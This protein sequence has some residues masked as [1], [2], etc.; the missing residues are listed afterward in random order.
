MQL[1]RTDATKTRNMLPWVFFA[2]L[3]AFI[4][5]VGACRP[6]FG[7]ERELTQLQTVSVVILFLDENGDTQFAGEV[8]DSNAQYDTVGDIGEIAGLSDFDKV[9]PPD[10]IPGAVAAYKVPRGETLTVSARSAANSVFWEWAEDLDGNAV[11]KILTIDDDITVGAVFRPDSDILG[12]LEVELRADIARLNTWAN[13]SDTIDSIGSHPFSLVVRRTGGGTQYKGQFR[14]PDVATAEELPGFEFQNWVITSPQRPEPEETD[15]NPLEIVL[16]RDTT[17]EAQYQVLTHTFSTEVLPRSG[18]GTLDVTETYAAPDFG[19]SSIPEFVPWDAGNNEYLRSTEFL[20]SAQPQPGYRFGGFRIEETG[21]GGSTRRENTSPLEFALEADQTVTGLFERDY[22]LERVATKSRATGMPDAAAA[23]VRAPEGVDPDGLGSGEEFVYVLGEEVRIF[24]ISPNGGTDS[25]YRGRRDLEVLFPSRDAVVYDPDPSDDTIPAVLF[26]AHGDDG[27]RA[28]RLDG[29]GGTGDLSS[30]LELLDWRGTEGSGRAVDLAVGSDGGGDDYLLVADGGEE[31]RL[32]DL[33]GDS[34][35]AAWEPVYAGDNDSFTVDDLAASSAAFSRVAAAGSRVLV[36]QEGP[37]PEFGATDPFAGDEGQ[38]HLLSYNA[39]GSLTEDGDSPIGG[40]ALGG[41][42][43]GSFTHTDEVLYRL[44]ALRLS[45]DGNTGYLGF[46]R[47]GFSTDGSGDVTGQ[48]LDGALYKLDINN[49]GSTPISNFITTEPLDAGD[50]VLSVDN[51]DFDAGGTIYATTSAA[52][53]GT[54]TALRSLVTA[55][56]GSGTAD[57]VV[58]NSSLQNGNGLAVV[59][60]LEGMSNGTLDA[61]LVADGENG[62]IRLDAENGGDETRF[63]PTRF[64][65]GAASGTIGSTRYVAVADDGEGIRIY[66]DSGDGSFVQEQLLDKQ[67]AGLRGLSFHPNGDYLLSAE[68]A[69]LT[70][71][72]IAE[73]ATPISDETGT[74]TYS[75][76]AYS[77]GV[78]HAVVSPIDNSDLIIAAGS[79]GL[80][81]LDDFDF[82][83]PTGGGAT[84]SEAASTEAQ[85]MRDKLL[86]AEELLTRR[87]AALLLEDGSSQRELVLSADGE[88]GARIVLRDGAGSIT[89]TAIYFADDGAAA[90]SDLSAADAGALD[91]TTD[92]VGAAEG[93]GELRDVIAWTATHDGAERVFAAFASVDEGL[94]IAE[95]GT[96]GDLIGDTL[97]AS[98]PVRL[99]AVPDARSVDF[100]DGMLVVA[101]GGGGTYLVDVTTIARP[102]VIRSYDESA[103]QAD[104]TLVYGDPNGGDPPA[105]EAARIVIAGSDA[106]D[107]LEYLEVQLNQ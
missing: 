89:D 7:P 48:E 74:G 102:Y 86:G 41:I 34:G 72:E 4:V 60:D 104:H 75:N 53:A 51:L 38:L 16:D 49:F 58:D 40:Q 36:V 46:I 67:S 64:I 29:L 66:S 26:S 90:N 93:V 30:T 101:G 35:G 92:T 99:R 103:F 52:G 32:Y 71:Y 17:L 65:R 20:L 44:Q 54:Q 61:A 59:P 98:K 11:G 96:L 76:G 15:E 91:P 83:D 18:W 73:A 69:G 55:D 81:S 77:D 62:L 2:L 23:V 6:F 24:E 82:A 43:P 79:A 13:S 39:G 56:L 47:E 63:A 78:Y 94:L 100:I 57:T 42:F 85:D 33:P 105:A 9:D 88:A 97:Q 8:L 37:L 28:V 14:A 5:T 3:G 21:T 95:M 87:V 27:V 68:S 10:D 50:A 22:V 12:Q 1:I 80:R 25:A 107:Y 70:V 45:S 19:Q 84:E 106:Q 31:L